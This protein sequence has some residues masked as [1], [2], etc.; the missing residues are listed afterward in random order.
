[1]KN[2]TVHLKQAHFF[3]TL[4]NRIYLSIQ[5]PQPLFLLVPAWDNS[6]LPPTS[7]NSPC[8]SS[9]CDKVV[10][11]RSYTSLPVS[12]RD[13]TGDFLP[14]ANPQPARAQSFLSPGNDAT[15]QNEVQ[16]CLINTEVDLNILHLKSLKRP[17]LLAA[18]ATSHLINSLIPKHCK[19]G[20]GSTSRSV[21]SQAAWRHAL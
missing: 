18:H 2:K 19:Y 8:L 1:M 14:N 20:R 4:T 13:T 7:L 3:L 11:G 6:V 17:K 10:R 12:C 9:V 16:K 15:L 21:P 5:E